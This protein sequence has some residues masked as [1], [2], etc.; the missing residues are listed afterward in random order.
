MSDTVENKVSTLQDLTII[1]GR[2]LT[3]NK[4]VCG[5]PRAITGVQ[6]KKETSVISERSNYRQCTKYITLGSMFLDICA[7]YK[8]YCYVTQRKPI[9]KFCC[10]HGPSRNNLL[11]KTAL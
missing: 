9:S 2:Q 11:D 10:S 1:Q 8:L 3:K 7:F 6:R 5:S 4:K